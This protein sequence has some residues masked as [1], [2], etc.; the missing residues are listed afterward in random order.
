MTRAASLLVASLVLATA[1]CSYPDFQFGTT[2][3]GGTGGSGGS[4]PTG[5]VIPCK[6]A[7]DECSPGQVCCLSVMAESTCVDVAL[8][9]LGS[10][11][12]VFCTQPSDCNAGFICCAKGEPPMNGVVYIETISCQQTC[13]QSNEFIACRV[14]GDCNSPKVCKDLVAGDPSYKLCQ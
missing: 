12:P 4:P 3:S 6:V 9:C 1:S 7:G 10:Q 5:P 2:G 14:D 13:Q 11:I 8:D